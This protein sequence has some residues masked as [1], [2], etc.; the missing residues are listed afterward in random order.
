LRR[1]VGKDGG[2]SEKEARLE[3]KTRR[4]ER[5][6]MNKAAFPIGHTEFKEFEGLTTSNLLI[7]TKKRAPS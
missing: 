4:G 3:K 2:K 1:E 7:R 6:R 5:R